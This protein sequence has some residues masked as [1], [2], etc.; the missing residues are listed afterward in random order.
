MLERAWPPSPTSA[1][2]TTGV[3]DDGHDDTHDPCGDRAARVTAA[4]MGAGGVV[5]PEV[6]DDN[7]FYW[8]GLRAH[9]LLLQRCGGG[10]ADD[11]AGAGNGCG[12]VRFPP[13]PGCPYCGAPGSTVVESDG[14]GVV[15]SQVRVHRAFSAAFEGDVP[16]VIATVELAGGCR[17]VGR[18]EPAGA[19]GIGVAVRARFHDHP[20]WTELRFRVD[21]AA[22]VD[23]DDSDSVTD[24]VTDDVT[25]RVTADDAGG[26]D[27]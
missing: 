17:T 9:R 4:E 6:D 13:M 19:S 10:A 20:D 16:Y 3:G 27:G 12:R 22:G 25:D 1:P 11:S 8:E 26:I 7:A 24:D 5:A 14:R 21:A 15:Y 18:V 23:G 2:R